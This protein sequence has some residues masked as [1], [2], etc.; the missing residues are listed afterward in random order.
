MWSHMQSYSA[1]A[2]LTYRRLLYFYSLL[3][4][5]K[6]FIPGFSFSPLQIFGRVGVQPLVNVPICTSGALVLCSV[7]MKAVSWLLHNNWEWRVAP[8]L[9]KNSSWSE[10]GSIRAT[11]NSLGPTLHPPGPGLFYLL[12]LV[13][14]PQ[15]IKMCT[16]WAL[17]SAGCVREC[18]PGG[19][20]NK[21]WA[22]PTPSAEAQ[23][24][25][26]CFFFSWGENK[27]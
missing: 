2:A 7:D 6:I 18:C 20:L 22:Y 13:I 16:W 9:T 4:A 19:H 23:L 17:R 21:E 1:V 11:I 26:L 15:H 3:L 24:P 25:V 14:S 5:V 27:T 10:N 8:D 12:L